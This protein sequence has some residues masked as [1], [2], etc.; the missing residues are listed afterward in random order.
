MEALGRREWPLTDAEIHLLRSAMFAAQA[1]AHDLIAAGG[2]QEVEEI[3]DFISTIVS[4]PAPERFPAG[5]LDRKTGG[6]E[7]NDS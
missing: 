4:A 2:E 7:Q 3:R 5:H 6:D 1:I